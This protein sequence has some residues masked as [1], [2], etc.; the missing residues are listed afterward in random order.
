MGNCP[1]KSRIWRAL[2]AMFIANQDHLT[3]QSC[4]GKCLGL[5]TW[6]EKAHRQHAQ[7]FF[8]I[9]CVQNYIALCD[10][11]YTPNCPVLPPIDK[12]GWL[13]QGTVYKPVKS[14]EDPTPKAVIELAIC[15]CKSGCVGSRCKCYSNK[16]P[17]TPLRKC[18]ATECANML[19]E[20]RLGD[21]EDESAIRICRV[22]FCIHFEQTGHKMVIDCSYKFNIPYYIT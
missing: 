14:L 3:F 11:L 4:D 2:Y 20:V 8:P 5:G 13:I 9:L 10:K 6:K 17:C 22:L 1:H 21:I 19:E 16:L 18:Y 12:N 7:P 15:W